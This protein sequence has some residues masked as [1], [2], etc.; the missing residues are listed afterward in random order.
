MEVVKLIVEGI[1]YSTLAT[2]FVILIYMWF[3][4]VFFGSPDG[5]G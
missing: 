3:S 2:G 5:D 1:V 4:K